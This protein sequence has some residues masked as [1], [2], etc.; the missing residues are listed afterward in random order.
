MNEKLDRKIKRIK[1]GGFE[2]IKNCCENILLRENDMKK[3]SGEEHF[4]LLKQAVEIVLESDYKGTNLYRYY[5]ELPTVPHGFC[6]YNRW[7]RG[8]LY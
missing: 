5:Y 7:M 6:C 8:M 1:S 2:G 4:D 3:L